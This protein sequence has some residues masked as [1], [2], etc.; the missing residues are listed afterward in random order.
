MF[1][2]WVVVAW[3]VRYG[4]LEKAGPIHNAIEVIG[5]RATWLLPSVLTPALAFGRA[6]VRAV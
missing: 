6:V 4:G 5:R 1:V 3:G 2:G